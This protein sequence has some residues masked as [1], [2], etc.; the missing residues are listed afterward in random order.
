MSGTLPECFGHFPNLKT[1]TFGRQYLEGQIP[2]SMDSLSTLKSVMLFSNIFVC[3][4][5]GLEG[6]GQTLGEGQWL[7]ATYQAS[8]S[9]G[10]NLKKTG[11]M[12]G[13]NF[14]E[15]ATNF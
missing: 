1:M 7:S 2:E 4:A 9:L 15:S 8:M 11:G 10:E 12:A 14:C 3:N 13:R 5:P 6:S